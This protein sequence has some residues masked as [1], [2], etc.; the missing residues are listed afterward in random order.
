VGHWVGDALELDE[1]GIMALED[2]CLARLEIL[3]KSGGILSDVEGAVAEQQ[4]VARLGDAEA[5]H[6]CAY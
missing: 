2:L 6:P 5:Y 3:R 4:L 1:Q